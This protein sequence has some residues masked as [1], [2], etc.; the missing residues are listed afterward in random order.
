M[1]ELE[2]LETKSNERANKLDEKFQALESSKDSA[3]AFDCKLAERGLALADKQADQEKTA[4]EQIQ[5]RSRLDAQRG[6]LELE[7]KRHDAQVKE[8]ESAR[9]AWKK[10]ELLLK[11]DSHAASCYTEQEIDHFVEDHTCDY[12]HMTRVQRRKFVVDQAKSF[13]DSPYGDGSRLRK[14]LDY[15]ADIRN[16]L[17]HN[18]R[19]RE[20]HAAVSVMMFLLRWRL[21]HLGPGLAVDV[22]GRFSA[23][24]GCARRFKQRVLL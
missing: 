23:A 8:D 22:V 17:C 12:T 24:A 18:G 16:M 19:P 1:E 6:M 7:R 20:R 15:F 11:M 10:E 4:R 13:K 3:V 21:M 14:D 2:D 9:T 5:E